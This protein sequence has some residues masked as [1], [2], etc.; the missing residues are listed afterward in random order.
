MSCCEQQTFSTALCRWLRVFFQVAFLKEAY[1][2][3]FL[4]ERPIEVSEVLFCPFSRLTLQYERFTE[5]EMVV[6]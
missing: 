2:Q 4:C 3:L 1:R 5:N 6:S